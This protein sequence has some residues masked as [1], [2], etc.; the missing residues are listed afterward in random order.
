MKTGTVQVY[1]PD[2]GLGVIKVS[3]KERY[4]FERKDWLSEKTPKPGLYVQFETDG[5]S[6][7]RKIVVVSMA[8]ELGNRN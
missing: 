4:V 7:A 1:S 3:K 8:D 6:M 5:D 2:N